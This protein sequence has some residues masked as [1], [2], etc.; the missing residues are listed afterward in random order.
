MKGFDD[1]EGDEAE[2]DRPAMFDDEDTFDPIEIENVSES[3]DLDWGDDP[4]DGREGKGITERLEEY[5]DLPR[6]DRVK[7]KVAPHDHLGKWNPA[8]D[9]ELHRFIA[10]REA[11]FR[12]HVDITEAHGVWFELTDRV[13]CRSL[14]YKQHSGPGNYFAGPDHEFERIVSLHRTKDWER[15]KDLAEFDADEWPM[16]S[17]VDLVQEVHDKY[18]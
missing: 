1:S 9:E 3:T 6:D 13:D 8:E 4:P 10:L 12:I 7:K 16:D 17:L 18:A 2:N 14:G 15:L 5:E 11:G